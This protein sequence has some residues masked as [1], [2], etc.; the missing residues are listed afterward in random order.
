M[1]IAAEIDHLMVQ[2]IADRAQI[3]IEN[4]SRRGNRQ[5]LRDGSN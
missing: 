5:R 1:F 4:A 2:L 3:E